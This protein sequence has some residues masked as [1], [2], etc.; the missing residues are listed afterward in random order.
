MNVLLFFQ[1]MDLEVR[2]TAYLSPPFSQMVSVLLQ[3]NME[4]FAKLLIFAYLT[5]TFKEFFF[6][7]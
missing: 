3:L 1:T 6:Y 5:R 2:E 7:K 4:L